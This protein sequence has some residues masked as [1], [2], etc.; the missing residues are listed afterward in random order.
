MVNFRP[1]AFG[2]VAAFLSGCVSPALKSFEVY[3]GP[4]QPDSD[5]AIV[6][7]QR[8]TL[9]SLD[10]ISRDGMLIW[11]RN[12]GVGEQVKTALYGERFD[13]V[14]VRLEPGRYRIASRLLCTSDYGFLS[15]NFK[16]YNFTDTTRLDDVELLPG[17]LYEVRGQNAGYLCRE[18]TRLWLQDKTTNEVVSV[19]ANFGDL[20]PAD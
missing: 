5:L 1:L 2:F 15:G 8:V 18:G 9:V 17:H 11:D 4:A 19:E 14:Q 13:Q 6:R 16:K 10:S 12:F 3:E 20:N 7:E